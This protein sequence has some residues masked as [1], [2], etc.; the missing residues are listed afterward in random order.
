[1]KIL[2]KKQT[3]KIERLEQYVGSRR[4]Y[5][6]IFDRCEKNSRTATVTTR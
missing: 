6:E 4:R 1:M 3:A 2:E 5:Q